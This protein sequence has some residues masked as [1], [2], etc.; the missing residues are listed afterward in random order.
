MHGY[1][2]ENI[3]SSLF[4]RVVHL[5]YIATW[6]NKQHVLSVTWGE[7]AR[8]RDWLCLKMAIPMHLHL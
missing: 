4:P 3:N 6:D 2:T 7:T 8:S 1:V 5:A